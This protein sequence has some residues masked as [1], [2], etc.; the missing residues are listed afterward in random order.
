M[1]RGRRGEIKRRAVLRLGTFLGAKAGATALEYAILS[2]VL[3]L[4]VGTASSLSGY[5]LTDGL[6]QL[7]IALSSEAEAKV[8]GDRI[9][10]A[11]H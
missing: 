5:G 6:G 8:S 2:G 10:A 1:K 4:I 7:K 11:G 3:A 9:F